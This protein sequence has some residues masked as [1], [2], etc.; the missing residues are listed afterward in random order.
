MRFFKKSKDRYEGLNLR[1]E[2]RNRAKL[3]LDGQ[4]SYTVDCLRTA[5]DRG[6]FQLTIS[7]VDCDIVD[8][9]I[10]HLRTEGLEVE[11]YNTKGFTVTWR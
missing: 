9:V 7:G 2:L 1:D 4:I 6:D 5:A 3:Y 8:A 11:K 10:D